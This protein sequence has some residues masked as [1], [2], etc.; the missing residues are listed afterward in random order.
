MYQLLLYLHIA[1][2]IIAFGPTFSLPLIGMMAGREPAHSNFALRAAD[3]IARRRITPLAIAMAVTG[4]PLIWLGRWDLTRALWLDVA[5]V[6][7][8]INFIISL[9]VM[10]PAAARLID[11]T[12]ARAQAAPSGPPSG[13]PPPVVAGLV[14]RT[15]LGGA[16]LA[17]NVLV[18]LALMVFKPSL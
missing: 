10:T 9:F 2:A 8:V 6:L 5:I 16:A 13:G 18:I 14:R 1:S 12:A 7:Y 17:V 4:V 3:T 11:L 15:Q